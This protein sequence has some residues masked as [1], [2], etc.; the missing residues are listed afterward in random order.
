MTRF[1]ESKKLSRLI[2]L[3]ECFKKNAE[4]NLANTICQRNEVKLLRE[5][6]VEAIISTS[7][8]NPF[9]GVHYSN[10]YQE[11]SINDKKMADLQCIQEKK[12][13]S[14]QVK[15]DRLTKIKEEICMIEEREYEDENNQD[16]I[17]VR[18]SFNTAFHKF[19]SS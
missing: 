10:Y 1:R 13:L 2:S 3:Q 8:T 7:F 11:L 6:L 12:L 14:K 16:N 19:I 15:I 18:I 4:R 9:L 5:E 17:D